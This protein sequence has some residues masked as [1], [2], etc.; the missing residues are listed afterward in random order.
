MLRIQYSRNFLKSKKIRFIEQQNF[1][2]RSRRCF[3]S[4]FPQKNRLISRQL[5]QILQKRGAF[6]ETGVAGKGT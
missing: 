5:L 3:I 2:V 6:V 4:L 1:A